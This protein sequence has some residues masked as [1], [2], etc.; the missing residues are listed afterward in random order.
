MESSK[1]SPGI[2]S[3]KWGCLEIEGGKRFKDAKLYPGGARE[4]D[5]RET[6]TQHV[7]GIQPADVEELIEKGATAIVLSRG[8]LKILQVCPETFQMLEEKNIPFHVLQTELAVA[9]YN[10]LR[11]KEPVGGLFHSTC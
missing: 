8:M 6:G 4:W 11:T 5:W 10:D 2:A 9:L 7:P 1:T 3:I